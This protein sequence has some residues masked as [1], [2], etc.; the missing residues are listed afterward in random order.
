MR[1]TSLCTSS[2]DSG[3]LSFD[4]TIL[5]QIRVLDLVVALEGDDA[6]GRIFDDHDQDAVA[7]AGDLDVLEQARGVE[8]LERGVDGFSVEMS[9][10]RRDENTSGPY[11]RRCADCR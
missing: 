4:C 2:R 5:F 11:R 8:A 3:P 9:V 10:R 1:T 6:D 7:V